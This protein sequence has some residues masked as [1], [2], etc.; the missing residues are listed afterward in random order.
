[1][2]EL[3][4]EDG[5]IKVKDLK[6]FLAE[7]DIPDDCYIEIDGFGSPAGTPADSALYDPTTNSLLFD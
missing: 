4:L 2:I 5:L 7:N 6:Q 1:M 3:A